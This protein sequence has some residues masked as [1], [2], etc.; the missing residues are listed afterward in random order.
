M[1]WL[2][3]A[4]ALGLSSC[5]KEEETTS[6]DAST[7]DVPITLASISVPTARC[8]MCEETIAEALKKVDGVVEANVNAESDVAQVKFDSVKANL[9]SLEL[10]IAKAGYN[11]NATVRDSTAHAKLHECCQ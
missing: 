8:E 3:V 5:A 10:A 1:S 4:L 7:Q 9:A 2:L 11:A 6:E